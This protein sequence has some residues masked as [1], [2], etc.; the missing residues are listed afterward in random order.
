MEVV[1]GQKAVVETPFGSPPI[2]I[3][4]LCGFSSAA[5][6]EFPG[7]CLEFGFFSALNLNVRKDRC[8]G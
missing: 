6:E 1:E 5:F 8:Q 4:S 7:Q 2:F 3:V